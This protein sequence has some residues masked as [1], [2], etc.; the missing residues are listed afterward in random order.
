VKLSK[1]DVVVAAL[2]IAVCAVSPAFAATT[3]PWSN[4][5][6]LMKD[7][8]TGNLGKFLA[9][10]SVSV[11]AGITLVTHRFQPL[12][13]SVIIA[14]VLGGAVG[15]AKLFFSAGGDAFGTSW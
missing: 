11:G 7:W 14:V 12:A 15:L 6:T 2:V 13:W 1:A 5:F 8:I 9:L 10:L 3:D 4:F